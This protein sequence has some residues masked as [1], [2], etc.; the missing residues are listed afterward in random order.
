M[1]N[2]LNTIGL[3]AA[4]L[5]ASAAQADVAEKDYNPHTNNH[6]EFSK[7]HSGNGMQGMDMTKTSMMNNSSSSNTVTESDG[8]FYN[9]EKDPFS[10]DYSHDH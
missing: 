4:L 5:I 2:L 1:K 6:I 10:L 9:A 7:A 8:P 3:T